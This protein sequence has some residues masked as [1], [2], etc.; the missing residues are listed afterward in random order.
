MPKIEHTRIKRILILQYQPFGDIIL[1]TGYMPHLRKKFPQAKI[2][3]LIYK[4]FR[5]VLEGN[6]YLDELILMEKLPPN[7]V[8]Y[9][10]YTLKMY[11]EIRKR[12]Y[13]LVI[14]QMRSTGSIQFVL[15]SGARYRLGYDHKKWNFIYNFSPKPGPIKYY[16]ALKLELL[17]DL[18]IEA[19]TYELYFN[20]KP[21]S[22]E[23]V[24]NWLLENKLKDR[25]FICCS[26]GSPISW[27]QWDLQSYA[28]LLDM[29]IEK[30][31][32]PVVLL[33]A[34]KEKQV[35]DEVIKY[36][37]QKAF[38]A[39][40]TDFNQGGAMLKRSKLLICND[41]GINHLSVAV[42]TPS[43]AIFAKTNPQRWGAVEIPGHYALQSE[44]EKLRSTPNFGITPEQVF[45]QFE[46]TLKEI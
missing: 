26:P 38:L 8:K 15:F 44:D 46:K 16:A 32:Y 37:Q 1:N 36:M 27:K 17:R 13:D 10:L 25:E 30:T 12:K 35:V 40:P 45:V 20:I 23:Y 34:P 2:D 14:D 33:W 19:E 18:G 24:D 11:F 29:I 6:P 22:L 28:K 41:G 7:T 5:Q 42:K 31:G 21:E 43:I 9:W 4:P 3:Y 39:P